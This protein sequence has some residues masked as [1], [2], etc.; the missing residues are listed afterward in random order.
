[1][2]LGEPT[3]LQSQFRLTY[4][5]I[6][7]LLRV[8]ALKIEEMIKR[9]FSENST[10]TMLPEHERQMLRSEE[11]LKKL[12]KPECPVCDTD[13]EMFHLH[14]MEV[15]NLNKEVMLWTMKTPM[16]KNIFVPKR[17]II[18]QEKVCGVFK[19]VS[20]VNAN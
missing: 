9:S 15:K 6:L 1:M 14:C 3:K 18:V 17:V 19:I 4:S 12:Q 7:N 20:T 8:E 2:I 13:L 5:M 10:Q 11:D 16:C